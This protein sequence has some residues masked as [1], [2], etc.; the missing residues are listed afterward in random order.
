MNTQ[1]APVMPRCSEWPH[2]ANRPLTAMLFIC[3]APR[4]HPIMDDFIAA[5]DQAIA[6]R[7][8]CLVQERGWNMEEF[9]RLAQLNRHT[10]RQILLARTPRRLRNATIGACARA[11]GLSVHDLRT[12]SLETL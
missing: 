8:A 9:A 7:I 1:V 5:T 3:Y 4:Y 6:S 2:E 12:Q 11:L 10:V